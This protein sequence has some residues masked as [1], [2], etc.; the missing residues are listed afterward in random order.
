MLDFVQGTGN[1]GLIPD[2]I[3]DFFQG[4]NPIPLRIRL[5]RVKWMDFSNI[6]I[7]KPPMIRRFPCAVVCCVVV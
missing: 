1:I 4:K 3:L 5:L 6:D 2:R 7:K